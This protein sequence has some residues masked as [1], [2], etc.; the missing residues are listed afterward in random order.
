VVEIVHHMSIKKGKG[1]CVLL[2][3]SFLPL[4]SVICWFIWNYF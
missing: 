4:A 1:G 3:P 2:L